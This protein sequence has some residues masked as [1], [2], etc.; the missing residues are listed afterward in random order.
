M[1]HKTDV[2]TRR[3]VGD[4]EDVYR[5]GPQ[6]LGWYPVKGGEGTAGK[7][8]GHGDQAAKAQEAQS[9]EERAAAA[10]KV[11]ERNNPANAAKQL[12]AIEGED[13]KP[14]IQDLIRRR[15]AQQK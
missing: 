6:G 8:V 12:E 1:A 3:K 14:T 11:F 9:A 4:R 13:R 10:K 15:K 2:G 7:S 5:D